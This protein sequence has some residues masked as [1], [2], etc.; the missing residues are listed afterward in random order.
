MKLMA[1]GAWLQRIF[2]QSSRVHIC[3]DVAATP[4][5]LVDLIDRFIDGPMRYPLEWDDFISWEQANPN[6]EAARREIGK[7]EEW[8]FS[9]D[10]SKI[11]A[12]SFRVVEQRNRLAAIVG[13]P[14][15]PL[16][17]LNATEQALIGAAE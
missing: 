2:V 1:L 11:S 16:P 9:R 7:H 5:D 10:S 6:V 13:R 4:G 15:R 12:Y 17:T 8:L 3:Q 14:Q